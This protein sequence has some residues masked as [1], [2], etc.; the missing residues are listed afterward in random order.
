[1][2]TGNLLLIM[3][4]IGL[5]VIL[6]IIVYT[7]GFFTGQPAPDSSPVTKRETTGPREEPLQGADKPATP[8]PATP[9]PSPA[10]TEQSAAETAPSPTKKPEKSKLETAFEYLTEYEGH[11][12][13][14]SRDIAA[15]EQAAA[16]CAQY[17]GHLVTI[18]S[19]GE[20]NALLTAIKAGNLRRSILIG[21]SDAEREGKWTWVTGEKMSFTYW[22]QGQPDDYKGVDP[23]GED[24][25]QIWF[26]R[27]MK[28]RYHWN[29]TSKDDKELFMMEIEPK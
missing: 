6:L 10:N 18:T 14:I 16:I 25:G 11:T 12:Y 29:D 17:G 5:L 7:C 24:Y 28:F 9:S 3:A 21:L 1:M 8:A 2:K 23:R 27:N 22:D 4:C 26:H 20:N 13:Y 19:S 15:W